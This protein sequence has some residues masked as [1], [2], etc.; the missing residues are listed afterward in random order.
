MIVGLAVSAAC[1]IGALVAMAGVVAVALPGRPEPW[2]VHLMERAAWLAASAA[3]SIYS[4]GFFAVLSSEGEFN[5]GASSVPAPACLEGFDTDTF[6][7]LSHHR[8][9]YLPLRFDCVLDDG[10]TYP[11][12]PNY[13]WM[14]WTILAL[15]GA[16]LAIGAGY[17][18]FRVRRRRVDPPVLPAAAGAGGSQRGAG[19]RP[20]GPR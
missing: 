10:T 16:L 2:P 12:D 6:Q 18:A 11:S 20:P 14:N 19:R 15:S 7:H 17:V 13:V 1:A 8:S 3:A 9:S 4:L 5:D